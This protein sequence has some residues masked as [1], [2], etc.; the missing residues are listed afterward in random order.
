MMTFHGLKGEEYT[1]D[2]EWID[3]Y[4]QVGK[5]LK[6]IYDYLTTLP[7]EDRQEWSGELQTHLW[8]VLDYICGNT[9]N[10][11]LIPEYPGKQG[12]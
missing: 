9:E 2:K 11:D 5:E 8:C 10:D 3:H 4:R 7:E 1:T 12:K 6:G